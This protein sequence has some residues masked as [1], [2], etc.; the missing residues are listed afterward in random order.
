MGRVRRVLGG[1]WGADVTGIVTSRTESRGRSAGDQPSGTYAGVIQVV[2]R[3]PVGEGGHTAVAVAAPDYGR[4]TTD[5]RFG[6]S[7]EEVT[8]RM[9]SEA[10][11]SRGEPHPEPATATRVRRLKEDSG[12]TWDQLRR[13]FGVSRRT[14]HMWAG[15]SRINAR[16]E[17]RL[18]HLE[19]VV[20][21]LSGTSALD[22]KRQLLS[23]AG[24][25]RSIFQQ[26]IAS[27]SPARVPRTDIEALTEST[28]AGHTVHGD[29][30]SASTIDD[31]ENL[32]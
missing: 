32:R 19:S 29:F 21:A 20:A 9:E 22:R 25:G 3:A 6:G 23:P 28:G 10:S 1:S 27:A 26:L 5:L 24:A 7:W 8:A 13:L 15:G 14:V 31:G 18:A 4:W 12:L 30:L 17:E 11:T 2:R 16:N